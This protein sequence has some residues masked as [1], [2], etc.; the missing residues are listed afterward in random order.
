VDASPTG[1]EKSSGA[2]ARSKKPWRIFYCHTPARALKIALDASVTKVFTPTTTG[3][4]WL[5]EG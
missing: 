4:L 1:H 2:G 5:T 3:G